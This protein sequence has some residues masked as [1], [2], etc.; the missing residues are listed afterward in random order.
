MSDCSPYVCSPYLSL[1]FLLIYVRRRRLGS[2]H[3]HDCNEIDRVCL[4]RAWLFTGLHRRDR[5][6]C[7]IGWLDTADPV[8][9]RLSAYGLPAPGGHVNLAGYLGRDPATA[10]LALAGRG[11]AVSGIETLE[12]D[13]K[14]TRLNSSH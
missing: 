1:L 11:I 7:F 5:S 4:G 3:C 12:I 8:R 6:F 10:A 9:R 13:R 2:L 14:S